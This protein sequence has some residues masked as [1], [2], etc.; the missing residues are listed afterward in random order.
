ML[1]IQ[2]GIAK[3]HCLYTLGAVGSQK[4]GVSFFYSPGRIITISSILSR[5]MSKPHQNGDI[6]GSIK[7]ENR[8]HRIMGYK[9]YALHNATSGVN[10]F[11]SALKKIMRYSCLAGPHL[12]KAT[13]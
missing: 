5:V 2:S 10:S 3:Y 12:N 4:P 1:A 13:R 6:S 8:L 9:L 7:Y 11:F